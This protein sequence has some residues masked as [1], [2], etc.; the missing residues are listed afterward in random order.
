[1]PS[2]SIATPSLRK[3]LI[4]RLVKKPRLSL[5]T[6][7]VLRRPTATSNALASVASEVGATAD[8]LDQRHLV[9]RREEVQADE[10]AGPV[11]AL[12][13]RR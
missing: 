5:T 13:E 10:V 6:I 7:G 2:A 9:D 11:D 8:D 4:T 12:G 3:V 1:M